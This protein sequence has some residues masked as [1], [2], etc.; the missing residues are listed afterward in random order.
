MNCLKSKYLHKILVIYLR[1]NNGGCIF[2]FTISLKIRQTLI[3][4]DIYDNIT[5]TKFGLNISKNIAWICVNI[6]FVPNN[7]DI[8]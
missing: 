4:G 8:K 1:N 7:N 6:N 3:K 2:F 5:L